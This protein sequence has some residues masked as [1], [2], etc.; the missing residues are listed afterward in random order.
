MPT[1]VEEIRQLQQKLCFFR[2]KM[3]KFEEYWAEQKLKG[4]KNT[5]DYAEKNIKAYESAADACMRR[6][7]ELME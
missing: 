3:R 6:I 7:G 5:V 4:S 1:K 2:W